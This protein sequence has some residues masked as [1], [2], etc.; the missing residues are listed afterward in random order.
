MSNL[1]PRHFDLYSRLGKHAFDTN[2]ASTPVE[3]APALLYEMIRSFV[4][5]AQTLNLSHTERE[6]K[7]TRQTVL[8]HIRQLEEIRGV[9]LF[10][11]VDRQYQL[12]NEGSAALPDAKDILARGNAWQLGQSGSVGSMQ[13]LKIPVGDLNFYQQQ[14]PIGRIWTDESILLRETFRAWAMTSGEIEHP[15]LKHV[16][17][18][19]NIYRNSDA[20]WISTEF[21]EKSFYVQILGSDNARS[22]IGLPLGAVPTEEHFERLV[23]QV[24]H[25]VQETQIARL[26]YVSAAVPHSRTDEPTPI[27]YQRLAMSGSYPDGSPAILT[28]VLPLNEVEHL[29]LDAAKTGQR[30]PIV[31]LFFDPKDAIF[32][33]M[34]TDFN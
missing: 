10:R 4:V 22:N 16:R 21:G 11:V 2:S 25:E 8:R 1:N 15:C 33:N 20:G 27:A 18:Y 9:K 24:F 3:P 31:E 32:E 6:L 7:S 17:P 26:D 12:T 30:A 34:R 13:Y 5:L 28:L 23:H 14:Q 19:L 29:G